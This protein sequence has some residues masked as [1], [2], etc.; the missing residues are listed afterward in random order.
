MKEFYRVV[1]YC[2]GFLLLALG[3]ILN[4]K[5]GLGVAPVMSIPYAVSIIW[6]IN[7][8]NATLFVY[9]LFVALQMLL[10]GKKFSTFDLLQ[11]PM[12]IVFS[13]IINIFNNM[14]VINFS[15]LAPKILFLILA[16][17]LTGIGVAITIEMKF[18]PI[19][20]D[21]FTQA[22]SERIGKSLGFT[23]NSVDI[24]CVLITLL[25]CLVF[26][27]KVI[28]IGLGTLAAVLG[29]GRSIA[30]FNKLFKHKMVA[31]VS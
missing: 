17:I 22:V 28:G 7:L 9:I 31:L 25:L 13:R 5:T 4:T 10:R 26:E 15:S 20:A 24:S 12:S 23:K 11:F 6:N 30:L 19:A 2:F 8:G 27:G 29:I 14:I 21:G 18:V 1:M 3:V 16:I